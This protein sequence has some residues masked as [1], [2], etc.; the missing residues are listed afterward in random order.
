ML[1]CAALLMSASANAATMYIIHGGANAGAP[2]GGELGTFDSNTGAFVSFGQPIAGVGFSGLAVASGQLYAS[3]ST[4]ALV[5]MDLAGTVSGSADFNGSGFSAATGDRVN[6]LTAA[7]DGTLY[8]IAR[9]G[10]L[11]QVATVDPLTG[12]LQVINTLPSGDGFY[13]IAYGTDSL[14]VHNANSPNFAFELDAG[15]GDILG[16]LAGTITGGVLGLGYNAADGLLYASDCCN[17]DALGETMWTIDPITGAVE[18]IID[19]NDDRRIQDIAFAPVPL[20]AAVWLFA[21]GLAMLSRLRRA[22]R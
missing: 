9:I 16:N 17:G 3:S 4:H 13:S 12:E 6:D 10:G 1:L 11:E 14:F 2:F 18:F 8:A 5:T 19:F 20:P 15:T 7:P 21:G 22:K